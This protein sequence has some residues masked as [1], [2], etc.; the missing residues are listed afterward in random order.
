LK[1]KGKL[2]GDTDVWENY[3]LRNLKRA[4]LFLRVRE[5][6][7]SWVGFATSWLKSL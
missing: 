2:D 5:G 4:L 7:E 6:M 1:N 3:Q